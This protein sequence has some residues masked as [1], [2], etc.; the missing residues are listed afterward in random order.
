MK[1]IL[2]KTFL[3]CTAFVVVAAEAQAGRW[4]SRDP[5]ED[6]AGFVQREPNPYVFVLNAPIDYVD[7]LGLWTRD[8]WS[9]GWGAYAGTATAECGDTLSGLA[10]LTTGY[11]S[12]WSL[13]GISANI[14]EGQKV[15]IAPLLNQLED[16]LRKSVAGATG[17]LRV[18][19]FGA[20][21]TPYT[22]RSATEAVN[23]FF[24]ATAFGQAD[25]TA[26][27]YLVMAKGLIDV[28]KTG[29]FDR[30]KYTY[31]TFPRTSRTLTKIDQMKLG[32]WGY[33]ENYADY[34]RNGVEI[35]PYRGENVI[36]V[37]EGDYWGFG[38]G[39]QTYNGWEAILR[40][41]YNQRTGSSRTDALPGFK[42]F[43]VFIHVSHVGMDVFD[44]RKKKN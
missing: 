35:G 8:S 33:I 7:P 5:I 40:N 18:Q 12:D 24:G 38:G 10:V 22:G 14:K 27:A 1:T 32:D 44:L 34:V 13:L 16:R 15:N 26:A 3:S 28:L 20:P 37:G 42:N 23:R 21:I 30:L 25:C 29:E 43:A 6:G 31:T 11:P 19:T 17:K 4:L 39:T 2:Q 9:G 41:D 36:K